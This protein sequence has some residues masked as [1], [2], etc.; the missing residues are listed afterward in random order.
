MA[1]ASGSGEGLDFDGGNEAPKQIPMDRALAAL[2]PMLEDPGVLKVGQNIKYDALVF[3]RRG[4]EIGPVDDT[5]LLS[6]V[7]DGGLHGHG[8]DELARQHL[9]VETIKFKDVAGSGKSLVTFDKV[10]LDKVA[11]SERS[12]PEAW[13]AKNRIDVT[14]DFVRYARP[15]I[16]DGWPSIPLVDGRQRF[17][18]LQPVFARQTLAPYVPQA[19]R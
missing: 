2:K 1:S 12:F 15:L 17:A 13:I 14:D 11:N 3:A 7:L 4:I 10:P 18:Q 5:M 6:Y 8:M 9:G 16:G 19:H